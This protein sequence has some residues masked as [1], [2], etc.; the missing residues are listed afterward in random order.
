VRAM[1]EL[2]GAKLLCNLASARWNKKKGRIVNRRNAVRL[3]MF[4]P[5]TLAGEIPCTAKIVGLPLNLGNLSIPVFQNGF[6]GVIESDRTT[7]KLVDLSGRL[8]STTRIEVPGASVAFIVTLAISQMG[9]IVAAVSAKDDAGRLASLLVFINPGGAINRIV[10]LDRFGVGG[11]DFLSD[12]TIL[13]VGREYDD[14]FKEVPGHEI[15]RFYSSVGSFL[16][17]ALRVDLLR[18][19]RKAAHP[20]NWLMR[21]NQSRIAL[22]DKAGLRYCELDHSGAILRLPEAI[23]AFEG[24]VRLNGF[25]LT[26]DGDRV[27][28]VEAGEA[29]NK[30]VSF[31]RTTSVYRF[32]GPVNSIHRRTK[33]DESTSPEWVRGSMVLGA[34]RT[35]L[36]L[37]LFPP[38]AIAIYPQTIC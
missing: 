14:E 28:S 17:K 18:P 15:L 35:N 23:P 8:I 36:V 33:L 11:I 22:V 24:T 31:G 27:V 19:E 7:I 25:A 26:N 37:M 13:C 3:L 5:N 2:L 9:G 1:R 32:G 16:R 20:L 4:A 21:V 12:G 10:R 34:D 29:I 38:Q 6:L 30:A